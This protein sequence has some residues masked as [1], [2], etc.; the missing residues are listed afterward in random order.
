MTK[1]RKPNVPK[2]LHGDDQESQ[3]FLQ[4]L[5]NYSDSLIPI[6]GGIRWGSTAVPSSRFLFKDGQV[7]NKIDFPDLWEYA[8]TDATYTTTATTITLPVD[9]GFVVKAK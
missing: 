7:V 6:G 4:T 3:G 5:S 8:Q 9:A 1:L 2:R